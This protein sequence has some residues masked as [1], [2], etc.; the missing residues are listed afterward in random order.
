MSGITEVINQLTEQTNLLALNAAIEA[1]RAGDYGRG[2]AVVADE[3]RSL[4]SR[5]RESANDIMHNI[6]NVQDK[7]KTTADIM[8]KQEGEISKGVDSANVA[9]EALTIIT[10]SVHEIYEYNKTNADYSSEQ[11]ELANEVKTS[12]DLIAELVNQ[13][14]Q[15]NHDIE[16]SARK[17]SQI[18]L[19]LNS[20]TNQFQVGA[21]SD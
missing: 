13:V 4:A 17:I 19:Q 5:T 10:K 9:G 15:G 2:F 18:S 3:V 12:T 1:A 21:L 6:K 11:S 8:S 16:E 20:I 14:L 7:V